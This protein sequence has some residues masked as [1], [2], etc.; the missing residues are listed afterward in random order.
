MNLT[1]TLPI[2][3]WP[4]AVTC[5]AVVFMLIFYRPLS[6]LINRIKEISR[7]GII[8]P[9]KNQ[10]KENTA[11][12]PDIEELMQSFDL[13]SLKEN[14]KLIRKDL[15][16]K[17]LAEDTETVKVL[18]RHFAWAQLRALFE[19]ANSTI[20]G[21][22]LEALKVMNGTSKPMSQDSLETF[23]DRARKNFPNIYEDFSFNQWL[24]YLLGYSFIFLEDSGYKIS[25]LGR[26]FLVYLT[27]TGKS[28]LRLY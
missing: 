23:Y 26:D 5:I 13:A 18:V 10:Q 11:D 6:G 4:V 19:S 12:K 22:Q 17:G 21:T 16:E 27:S 28:E 15:K 1:E 8:S 9:V 20:Y 14:E 7:D 24:S 2:I 25:Q 3:V